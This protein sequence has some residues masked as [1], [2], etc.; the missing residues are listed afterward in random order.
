[1][2]MHHFTSAVHV[3]SN[4]EF[5]LPD[6]VTPIIKRQWNSHRPAE[7][8]SARYNIIFSFEVIDS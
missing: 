8:T 5:L 3:V 1:M 7:G 6:T 4:V 2:A